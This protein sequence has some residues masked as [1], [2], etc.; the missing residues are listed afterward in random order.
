MSELPPSTNINTDQ[1]IQ[2]EPNK[3]QKRKGPIFSPQKKSKT[4]PEKSMKKENQR[5]KMRTY[6]IKQQKRWRLELPDM[7]RKRKEEGAEEWIFLRR[8]FV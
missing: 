2:H 5:S 3:T 4:I 8:P 1:T 6:I 7:E